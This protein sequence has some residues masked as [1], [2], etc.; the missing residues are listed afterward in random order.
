MLSQRVA[1]ASGF[2]LIEM[3][4]V[5]ALVAILASLAAPSLQ[6][7]I[8]TQQLKTASFDLYASLAFART[9]A[10]KYG[11]GTVRVTPVDSNWNKGW[12]VSYFD[13]SSNETVLRRHEALPKVTIADPD[14][15]DY[16]EFR[17]NG[18]PTSTI[19]LTL[20]VTDHSEIQ[21]RCVYVD[22]TGSPNTKFR[23][24]DGC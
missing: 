8:A 19:S 17:R 10:V 12:T 20:T 5:V 2:T 11:S 21:G 18:R 14:S 1:K 9:E 3:M 15:N 6:T 7:F 4:V 24:G 22:P 16:F 13:S 23:P